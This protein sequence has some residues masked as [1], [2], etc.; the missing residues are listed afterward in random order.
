LQNQNKRCIFVSTKTVKD[1]TTQEI[2]KERNANGVFSTGN[3]AAG[4]FAISRDGIN[5]ITFY[6]GKFTFT[7]NGD[8]N[9]FY[10]EKVFA[11]K[12]TKLLNGGF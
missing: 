12:I 6:E 4:W 1:M 8:V 11:Q 10:T 5:M 3:A 9:K 7:V 2:N